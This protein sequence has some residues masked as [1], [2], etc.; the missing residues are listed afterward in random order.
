MAK[1][2]DMGFADDKRN[3]TVLKAVGG[4]VGKAVGALIRLGE[5]DGAGR[6]GTP[7]SVDGG[8]SGLNPPK[9][10]PNTNTNNPFDLRTS[11][12]QEALR[13]S[14]ATVQQVLPPQQYQQHQGQIGIVASLPSQM[15][16]QNPFL[17]YTSQQDSQQQLQQSF[18]GLQISQPLFPNA[19]GGYPQQQHQQFQYQETLTPPVSQQ[20]SYFIQTQP[21]SQQ[22]QPMNGSYNPFFAQPAQNIVPAQTNPYSNS[23]LPSAGSTFQY[24]QPQLQQQQQEQQYG[25]QAQQLNIFQQPQPLQP[26]AQPT[27]MPQQPTRAPN[28]SILAL[29]NY[30][31]KAPTPPSTIPNTGAPSTQ[32][33]DTPAQSTQNL[34]PWAPT[35]QG[36]RSVS[37]PIAPSGSRNPFLSAGGPGAGGGG[38]GNSGEEAKPNGVNRHTSQESVDATM[39]WQSGR[40]SPDAFASLSSR[41]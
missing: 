6:S 29:Y 26:H 4:D 5:N 23:V 3:S 16:A 35:A 19:T 1:L 39:G 38:G 11:K 18:Q 13:S 10:K 22:Q 7:V 25:L 31:Q 15:N 41:F 32:G 12:S 40:H 14:P 20:Q 28:S 36:N 21:R 17:P 37:T 27:Q 24:I 34:Q 30:P 33:L 8:G 9:P 2:R